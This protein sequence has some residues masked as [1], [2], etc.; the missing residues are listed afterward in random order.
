MSM[1]DTFFSKGGGGGFRGAKWYAQRH[2]FLLGI[3]LEEPGPDEFTM[4]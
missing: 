1:L 2:F 3:F 4:V